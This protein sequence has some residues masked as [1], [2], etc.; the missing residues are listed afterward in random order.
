[1]LTLSCAP[2]WEL[3]GEGD[4]LDTAVADLREA[5]G[6]VAEF[7][8]PGELTLMVDMAGCLR[9]PPCGERITRASGREPD[10]RSPGSPGVTTSCV[11]L[12]GAA[13]PCRSIPAATPMEPRGILADADMTEQELQRLL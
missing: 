6:L 13:P 7:G 9:C 10:S 1:V 4:T 3:T 12:T 2:A 5:L 11:I 8:A